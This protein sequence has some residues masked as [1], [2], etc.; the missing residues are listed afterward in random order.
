V[1]SRE[2]FL[3]MS[4]EVI[5]PAMIAG[6]TKVLRMHFAAGILRL[7]GWVRKRERE[8]ERESG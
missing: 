3:P 7:Q 1:P 2:I 5:G 8:R 6:E 4:A